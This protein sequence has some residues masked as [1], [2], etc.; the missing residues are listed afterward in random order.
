MHKDDSVKLYYPEVGVEV[1]G[2]G[3]MLHKFTR[4]K[5]LNTKVL[6]IVIA[7]L[8][9]LSTSMYT[10]LSCAEKSW[11]IRL[12]TVAGDV[13]VLKG[14][15]ISGT[16]L[17]ADKF[18][19]DFTMVNSKSTQKLDKS[20]DTM[21]LHAFRN[22]K[23]SWDRL[24]TEIAQYEM[25][26][27]GSAANIAISRRMNNK[28]NVPTGYSRIEFPTGYYGKA[29]EISSEQKAARENIEYAAA[30]TSTAPTNSA[31]AQQD[32]SDGISINVNSYTP[33]MQ[34]IDGKLYFIIPK[35]KKCS[36]NSGLYVIDNFDSSQT[37]NAGYRKLVDIP[38]DGG[39]NEMIALGKIDGG[40]YLIR[41]NDRGLA[42]QLYNMEKQAFEQEVLDE[43]VIS[44]DNKSYSLGIFEVFSNSEY[45]NV[46]FPGTGGYD[47][48]TYSFKEGLRRQ[49]KLS[50]Y[51]RDRD[52][53]SSIEQIYYYNNLL[54]IMEKQV[55]WHM[56]D[57]NDSNVSANPD[58]YIFLYAYD[59]DGQMVYKGEL[60][61]GVNDDNLRYKKYNERLVNSS[62]TGS[63]P[64]R[65]YLEVR[66]GAYEF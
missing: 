59:S 17:D 1:G 22:N 60:D 51:G 20:K 12:N 64:E 44:K 35:V 49:S 23:G 19:L 4:L 45:L 50:N 15:K 47:I 18:V 26:F 31:S 48:Y 52:N 38:L 25:S 63:V 3:N 40:L 57:M 42:L 27:M 58:E 34:E 10:V 61:A 53:H 8:L 6:F 54:Y 56:A 43:N 29:A 13:D 9:I 16:V 37:Q 24:Y 28:N 62:R 11:D 33:I 2:N 32:S 46:V 7:I 41:Y 30:L 65:R 36:G 66:L 55:V 5:S 39:E 21:N 14:L